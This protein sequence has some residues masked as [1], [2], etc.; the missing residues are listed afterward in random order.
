MNEHYVYVIGHENDGTIIGPVKVGITNSLGSRL[1]GIQTGNPFR[2]KVAHVLSFATRG[3]AAAIERQF[4]DN[5]GDERL[6]GEWFQI[7]PK[8]ALEGLCNI[9][10]DA[11]AEIPNKHTRAKYL[12]ACGAADP[13][14]D[15]GDLYGFDWWGRVSQ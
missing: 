2:L 13:I 4:H 5:F 11:V 15:L 9:V 6:N 1:C 14:K 10:I 8:D 3:E 7:T 12:E